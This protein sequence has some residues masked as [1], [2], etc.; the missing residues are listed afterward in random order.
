MKEKKSKKL[1]KKFFLRWAANESDI[2]EA[3]FKMIAIM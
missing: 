2:N 1:A 3:P